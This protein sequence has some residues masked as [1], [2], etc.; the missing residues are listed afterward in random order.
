[1]LPYLAPTGFVHSQTN[2]SAAGSVVKTVE[3]GR[4]LVALFEHCGIPRSRVSL[5]VPATVAGLR[6]CQILEAEGITTLGT[7]IC[8]EGQ[9]S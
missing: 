2:P 8:C 9:V 1:M 3:H 4:S 7:V 6:A 5:K